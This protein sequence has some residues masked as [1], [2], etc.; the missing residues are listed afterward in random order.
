MSNTADNTNNLLSQLA[1]ELQI[2]SMS[3]LKIAPHATYRHLIRQ[4]R[5]M[6][7]YIR[8]E[9]RGWDWTEGTGAL[10]LK[11]RLYKDEEG[12]LRLTSPLASVANVSN[13]ARFGICGEERRAHFCKPARKNGMTCV[14]QMTLPRGSPVTSALREVFQIATLS[15]AAL[16]RLF[17]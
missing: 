11:Q 15:P 2:E 7:Y 5:S 12:I 3:L 14:V 1:H 6:S 10:E 13:V 4:P 8:D 9:Q 17:M 16:F